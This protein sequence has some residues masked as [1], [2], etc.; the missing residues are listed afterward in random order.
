MRVGTRSRPRSGLST[1]DG[2]SRVRFLTP[3]A[4]TVLF[5]VARFFVGFGE[6]PSSSAAGLA[7]DGI[8]SRPLEEVSVAI[9]SADAAT[10]R[11]HR[12]RPL[13]SSEGELLEL[14]RRDGSVH[15]AGGDVDPGE[16]SSVREF[17]LEEVGVILVD[18]S[19]ASAPD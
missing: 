12:Q 6:E 9:R 14:F 19:G 17:S 5:F 11:V 7:G 15:F 13:P 4:A 1:A 2:S 3:A 16:S 10:P 8:G 18:P